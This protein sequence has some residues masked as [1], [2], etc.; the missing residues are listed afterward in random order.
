MQRFL[1]SFPVVLFPVMNL[2]LLFIFPY[3]A[4]M[5]QKLF[6]LYTNPE[7]SHQLHIEAG[8]AHLACWLT[9][10]KGTCTA[11]EYF[12]F[13]CDGSE[14]GFVDVFRELKR[15][16]ILLKHSFMA[17]EIVWENATFM[18]IPNEY[19]AAGK[20]TAYLDLV[21]SQSFQSAPMYNRLSDFTITYTADSVHHKIITQNIPDATHTHKMQH[22]LTGRKEQ[23]G[24]ALH[25]QFYQSHFLLAAIKDDALQ[26]ATVYPFSTPHEAVYHIL[27]T[28]DKLSMKR[29][30]THVFLSGFIDES[31]ALYKE[32]YLYVNN[33]TFTQTGMLNEE[34]PAHYFTTYNLP[35]A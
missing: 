11:L 13:S 15:Y 35:A 7:E 8:K 3:F 21:T 5:V 27:N 32:I 18:C 19:F 31:S 12:T 28:L 20:A 1:S 30:D 17:P 29:D 16:S 2:N 4:F 24:N 14:G 34:Y 23:S 25:L 33:L 22:L 10:E 26:V 9:D 6:S